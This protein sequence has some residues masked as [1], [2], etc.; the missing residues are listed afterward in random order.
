MNSKNNKNSNINGNIDSCIYWTPQFN[1]TSEIIDPL[2][3]MN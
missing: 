2:K 3:N 1:Y